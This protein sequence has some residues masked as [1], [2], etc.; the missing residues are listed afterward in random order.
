M[1]IFKMG[2]PVCNMV[3]FRVLQGYRFKDIYNIS[4]SCKREIAHNEI[5][6]SLDIKQASH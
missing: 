4:E 2:T 3:S 1:P 6:K 5:R